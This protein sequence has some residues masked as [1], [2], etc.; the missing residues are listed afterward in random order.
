M[1]YIGSNVADWPLEAQR[2]L[3]D[4]HEICARKCPRLLPVAF[5]ADV[6]PDTWSHS[7]S[8][9]PL[10]CPL[11]LYLHP[12]QRPPSQVRRSS[13]SYTIV[14]FDHLVTLHAHAFLA[15]CAPPSLV[16]GY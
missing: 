3:A 10:P 16:A 4:G 5:H 8:P 13:P 1:F 12:L 7:Y 2:A 11:R 9:F 15:V 14:S 6:S